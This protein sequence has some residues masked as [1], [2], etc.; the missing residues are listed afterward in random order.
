MPVEEPSTASITDQVSS[1]I[2]T[3]VATG[4]GAA[5]V[6]Y[7]IFQW[8]GKN[9]IENKFKQRLEEHRHQ[10]ALE[11][12]R[13]RV[14]IDSMLSGSIKLQEFEFQ[15]LPE[16]W[17]LLNDARGNVNDLMSPLQQ[18]PD[19]SKMNNEEIQDIL[20][21]SNLLE[22]QKK[23]IIK[24]EDK[25]K[26]YMEVI[27]WK[28]L[29]TARNSCAEFHKYIEKMGI[30]IPN[31]L[32]NNLTEASKIMWSSLVSKEVG[33]EAKEWKMQREGSDKLKNE[34]EPLFAVIQ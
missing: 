29:S 9:W 14:E 25:M 20:R 1:F 7:F 24:S 12:Q 19:L 34:F 27:F 4:G 16:A 5:V 30:F 8:L 2:G 3:I 21:S 26:T 22:S 11:I 23:K 18:Y 17:K 33:H 13:L 6:A 31:E 15:T 32:K 28:K 10:Q